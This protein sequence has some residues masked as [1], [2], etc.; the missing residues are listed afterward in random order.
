MWIIIEFLRFQMYPDWSRDLQQ[1]LI[2]QN[3]E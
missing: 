1:S 3:V 2:E